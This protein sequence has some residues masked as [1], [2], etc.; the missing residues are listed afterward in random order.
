LTENIRSTLYECSQGVIDILV[1]LFI[2]SQWR[3]MLTKA[4]QLS[5]DLILQ[6]Y[7]DEFKAV[8]PMLA[9]L[10]SGDPE[11]IERYGDLKMP[12]VEGKMIQAFDSEIVIPESTPLSKS[13][14]EEPEKI[15]KLLNI[16]NS[17]GLER[18]IALP[19][20]EMEIAKNPS[21]DVM[22]IIH[23]ITA[24][25]TQVAPAKKKPKLSKKPKI[26]N[27]QCLPEN[28][29]RNMFFHKEDSTMHNMLKQKGV[30][31][32]IADILRSD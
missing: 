16:T 4:E 20:I 27:W 9:A 25:M 19:L 5:E 21:M 13:Y 18:D 23:R 12:D 29:M 30:V 8:H 10:R 32:S 17:I 7:Q 26:E 14:S 2:L 15:E 31:V 24:Q 3:A 1:K 6:V 28:D 11:K 22:H